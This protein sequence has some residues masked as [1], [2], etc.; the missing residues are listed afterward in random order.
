MVHTPAGVAEFVNTTWC[1]LKNSVA[2]KQSLTLIIPCP[3]CNHLAGRASTQ[4]VGKITHKKSK[5]RRHTKTNRF[6]KIIQPCWVVIF[7]WF[8]ESMAKTLKAKPPK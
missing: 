4:F 2:A 7:A 8:A 6:P 3:V 1:G 5:I